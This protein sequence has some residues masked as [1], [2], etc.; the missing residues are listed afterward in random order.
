[1]A[2]GAKIAF[3]FGDRSEGEISAV[4]GCVACEATDF[5]RIRY[6]L[7]RI[8]LAGFKPAE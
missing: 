3:L 5:G 6:E 2:I 1:M 7:L 8:E 4:M